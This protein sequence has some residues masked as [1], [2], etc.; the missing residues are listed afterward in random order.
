MAQRLKG[1]GNVMGIFSHSRIETYKQCPYKFKLRYKDQLQTLPNTDPNN[2]LIVG[3]A[4]HTGIE[5]DVKTAINWYYNQFPV[6]SDEHVTEAMKL[7][8]VIPMMKNVLPHGGLYEV[9]IED[10]DFVGFIDYLVPLDTLTVI[11]YDLNDNYEWFDIYDFKYS[12]NVHNYLKSGQLHEYKYYFEKNNPNKKIRN[13]Y[14]VFAP[15]CQLKQKKNEDI[16]AFRRRCM[17]W[18]DN[19]EVIKIFRSFSLI[20]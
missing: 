4:L 1:G 14:F 20:Y 5:Q 13:L 18:I 9:K 7:E 17:D 3:T 19:N 8:K 10:E 11:D 12:N 16:Q 15:K 2:P 6:I